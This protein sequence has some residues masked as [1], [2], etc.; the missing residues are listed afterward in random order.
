MKS[1]LIIALIVII[2]G[3]VWFSTKQAPTVE[4]PTATDTTTQTTPT[5][6]PEPSSAKDMGMTAE[7][8]AAMMGESTQGTDVGMEMPM[9]DMPGMDHSTMGMNVD[10]TAKSFMLHGTDFAFDVKEIRVKKG[11]TVTINFM[12]MDG[13]H[14]VVIDEFNART[15]KIRTGGMS[16]ITF[17]ADK[18]GTFEYYCSVG[19]HRMNG[20]VGK[21][22]VE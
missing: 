8:H 18:A 19:S 11:D 20:M 2:G 22:I 14:D 7:E 21:L 6:S 9:E 10:A 17:V 1:L 12:S 16:S 3:A 4:A 15:E 5:P 13:F